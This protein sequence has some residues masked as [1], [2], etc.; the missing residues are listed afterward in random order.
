MYTFCETV[1]QFMFN[2]CSIF[3]FCWRYFTKE[4]ITAILEGK[5]QAMR[6]R[7]ATNLM[8]FEE[9]CNMGLS[10]TFFVPLHKEVV[11]LIKDKYYIVII[12]FYYVNQQRKL[13]KINAVMLDISVYLT[14]HC[15]TCGF[16]IRKLPSDATNTLVLY[17]C[18]FKKLIFLS[19]IFS[20]PEPTKLGIKDPW[21]K[22]T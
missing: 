21:M 5:L 14:D 6:L 12:L 7:V 9:T 2:N 10:F 18:S 17:N 11:N 15:P 16:C 4:P 13:K 8:I 1:H 20:S 3:L 22:G 19:C